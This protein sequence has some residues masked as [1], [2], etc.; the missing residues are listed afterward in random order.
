MKELAILLAPPPRDTCRIPAAQVYALGCQGTSLT[1]QLLVKYW[2]RDKR[3]HEAA[4]GKAGDQVTAP[5]KE[6]PNARAPTPYSI[7]N[8]PNPKFVQNLPQRLFLR[9]PVRRTGIC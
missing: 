6:M 2:E 7:Q 3:L 9:V 1:P 8:A 5:T 4:S